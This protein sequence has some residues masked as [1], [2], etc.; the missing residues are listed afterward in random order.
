MKVLAING[1]P[2][3]NWNT[4]ALIDSALKG[5][6]QA[7]AETELIHL[8]DLNFKG[9]VSC[10]ACKL[11]GGKSYGCCALKDDL[12]P[13]LK[14]IKDSTALILGSPIYFGCVTGEMRS[15]LE[16]LLFPYLVY[17]QNYS[18]LFNKKIHTAFI[19]TM[20]VNEERMLSAGYDYNL[21]L[22]AKVLERT[23]GASEW[24]CAN[25]TCQFDD[26]GKYESSAFDAAA[27][28]KRHKE[29]FPSDCEKAFALGK[30]LAKSAPI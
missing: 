25:D 29:V 27:K 5:A 21:T 23:L 16:R 13:V 11:K 7:G 4:A 26:Y 24:L 22:N 8:Y 2:R 10:F 28:V 14:K 30:K 18:S 1:S 9:C 19:Y 3:K 17:D 20:N 12:T 15:F 6:A